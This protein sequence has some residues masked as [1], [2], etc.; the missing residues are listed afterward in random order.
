M[1][2][3]SPS[4]QGKKKLP[5]REFL[6][7]LL[8][9]GGMLSVAGLQSEYDLVAKRDPKDDGWKLPEDWKENQEKEGWVL[10]DD[11]MDSPPNPPKPQ[12]RPPKPVPQPDGGVRPPIRGKVRP[13]APGD[14]SVPRKNT[15]G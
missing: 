8:F 4:Q 15:D 11:L 9:A 1:T 3:E 14:Y 13:P 12:P 10:P 5:R 6:A 2:Q 7:N